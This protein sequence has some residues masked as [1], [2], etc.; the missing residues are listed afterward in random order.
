MWHLVVGINFTYERHREYESHK[1]KPSLGPKEV[2]GRGGG[3]FDQCC[4]AENISFCSGSTDPQIRIGT[5]APAP[6]PDSFI[7]TYFQERTYKLQKKPSALKKEHQALQNM[8]FLNFLKYFCGSFLPSWIRIRIPNTDPDPLTLLNPDLIGIRIRNPGYI[9]CLEAKVSGVGGGRGGM[10]MM[11]WPLSLFCFWWDAITHIF[12][13]SWPMASPVVWSASQQQT[14]PLSLLILSNFSSSFFELIFRGC[15]STTLSLTWLKMTPTKSAK[16]KIKSL[17]E[18]FKTVACSEMYKARFLFC[19][20]AS[21]SIGWCHSHCSFFFYTA[22]F[23]G[24]RIP[25][26]CVDLTKNDTNKVSKFKH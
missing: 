20:L 7:R 17:K 24:L 9:L 16:L 11:T 5:P 15:V 10:I 8:K 6:A 26:S 13:P 12:L 14:P 4:G 21:C 2:R 23:S 1:I 18:L 22:D 19:W 25:P 3:G